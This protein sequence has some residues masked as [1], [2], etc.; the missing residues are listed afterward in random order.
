MTAAEFI[1]QRTC[2]L[3]RLGPFRTPSIAAVALKN[4]TSAN[5]IVAGSVLAPLGAFL[6]GREEPPSR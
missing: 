3:W 5:G 2:E 1:Q 6:V 4:G